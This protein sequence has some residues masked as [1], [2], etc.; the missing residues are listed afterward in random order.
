[1]T[2]KILVKPKKTVPMQQPLTIEEAAEYRRLQLIRARIYHLMYVET[3]VL[4]EKTNLKEY[5]R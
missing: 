1:M 5:I 2:V 4:S 3:Y